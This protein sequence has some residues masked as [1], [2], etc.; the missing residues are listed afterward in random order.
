MK[1]YRGENGHIAYEVPGEPERL[2]YFLEK[3][4]DLED[5]YKMCKGKKYYSA[6]IRSDYSLILT[7]N[8]KNNE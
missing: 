4:I 5:A 3:R 7:V 6:P 1:I 8:F 2:Y